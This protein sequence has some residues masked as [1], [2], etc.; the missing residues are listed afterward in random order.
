MLRFDRIRHAYN[1]KTSVNDVSFHVEG[2]EVVSLLGPSGCG[3]TT[4]LRLAAGLEQPQSGT[5]QLHNKLI[6]SEAYLQPPEHRGIGYMF[7]D[8]ALFP[9]FNS[10]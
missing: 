6:S 7:Q 8:Y 3:K 4:L 2:G 5:I 10:H 9:Q 1:G